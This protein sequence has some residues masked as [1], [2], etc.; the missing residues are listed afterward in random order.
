MGHVQYIEKA[1]LPS[2]LLRSQLNKAC[3]R[4]YS[5]LDSPYMAVP[6]QHRSK[7]RQGQRRMHIY[8]KKVSSIA[9]SKCSKPTL[10]H[11]ICENCGFY[12]GR[13][14]IDVL[15]KLTKKDRKIKEREVASQ[16]G[17]VKAKDKLSPEE[18]SR[19]NS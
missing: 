15:A 10:A 12:R 4:T 16:Q 13:E 14:A 8:L 3:N 9:C 18:L 7:S 5:L 17:E 19:P 11:T 6:K 2:A 1:F